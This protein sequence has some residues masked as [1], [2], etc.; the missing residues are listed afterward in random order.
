[1]A[2]KKVTLAYIDNDAERKASFKKRKKGLIKKLSEIKILC[3]VEA[4]AVIY[5]PFEPPTV[6]PSREVAY[7]LIQRFK[8]LPEIEKTKKMVNQE[9]FIQHQLKRT[10]ERLR[11]L[12]KENR[13]K[14]MQHF[15]YMVVEGKANI[16]DFDYRDSREMAYMIHETLEEISA[17]MKALE[18]A[19]ATGTVPPVTTPDGGEV[20]L[21]NSPATTPGSSATP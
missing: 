7:T 21:E 18:E 19:G 3:G 5:S 13:R 9:S 20:P 14:E 6:W 17:R 10:Q 4:C 15:M 8:Q 11:R 12:Q 2:R 1:M 16:K